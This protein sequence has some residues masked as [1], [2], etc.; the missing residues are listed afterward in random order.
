MNQSANTPPPTPSN[1]TTMPRPAPTFVR[2]TARPQW[3]MG[4]LLAEHGGKR[5]YRFEDSEVRTFKRGFFHLLT[6]TRPPTSMTD[7][8]LAQLSADADAAPGLRAQLRLFLATYRGGFEDPAWLAKRRGVAVRRP[9]KR[10]RE[11]V[12]AA[13]AE[14]LA[15]A[16][17]DARIA[18]GEHALLWEE[19]CDLLAGTDLVP[20]GH[21]AKLRAVA[22]SPALSDALRGLLHGGGDESPRFDALRRLIGGAWSWPIVSTL[23]ALVD[24]LG[25]VPIRASVFSAQARASGVTIVASRQPSARAYQAYLRLARDVRDWLIA[26]GFGPRDLIDVHDFIWETMRPAAQK[27]LRAQPPVTTSAGPA[28]A[29]AVEAE[30]EAA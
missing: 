1:I 2:H 21:V 7:L 18:A 22:A 29:P 23:R 17:L 15:L 16:R 5:S 24:P 4:A 26:Q 12:L 19:T 27:Q 25:E 3:G 30:V 6:P 9:L 20:A 10:H 11:P 14:R 28:Q 8:E 13:A